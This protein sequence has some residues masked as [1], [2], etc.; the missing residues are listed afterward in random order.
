MKYKNI[1]AE[2]LKKLQEENPDAV[3][4][5]VRTPGEVRGGKI[6]GATTIDIMDRNFANRIETL[7]KDKPYLV[8]CRSGNRSGQACSYMAERGFTRLYNLNGGIGSWPYELQ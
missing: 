2:E 6:P 1:G 7:D 8:Y 4:L 3:V 5:D